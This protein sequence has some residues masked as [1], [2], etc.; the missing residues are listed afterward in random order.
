MNGPLSMACKPTPILPCQGIPPVLACYQPPPDSPQPATVERSICSRAATKNVFVEQPLNILDA[1]H[2]LALEYDGGCESLAPRIGMS[3]HVL[4]NKVNPNNKTHHLTLVEALRMSVMTKDRR[5]VEA[6][7]REL[8]LVCMDV[9]QPENCADGEVLE[10][11]SESM[12]TF[13]DIGNEITKT[14]ADGRV[15]SRESRRVRDAIWA[16]LSKLFGLSN[17]IEGMAEK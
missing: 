2:A 14:F 12:K 17:R 1:A 6:F 4:R 15:E 7:A 9:P 5:I 3:A 10:M 16:H 11:M 13:G 8:G